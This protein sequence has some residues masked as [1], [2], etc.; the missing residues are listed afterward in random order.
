MHHTFITA[1]IVFVI[2]AHSSILI[3][4]W[5]CLSTTRNY[6]RHYSVYR[7]LLL[8]YLVFLTLLCHTL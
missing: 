7:H 1:Q 4:S 3:E 8:V 5:L 2:E 6:S